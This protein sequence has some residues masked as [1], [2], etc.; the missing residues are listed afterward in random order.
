M[1]TAMKL[2]LIMTPLMCTM[3][4]SAEQPKPFNDQKC[5]ADIF[6]D[7]LAKT[8][9]MNPESLEKY[10]QEVTKQTT[11]YLAKEFVTSYIALQQ[12]IPAN[13]ISNADAATAEL[14]RKHNETLKQTERILQQLPQV[15]K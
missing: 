4:Y 6:S 15:K 1:K 3:A 8:D 5:Y 2:Y 7:F 14:A 13:F 9:N 11:T 12:E 10:E